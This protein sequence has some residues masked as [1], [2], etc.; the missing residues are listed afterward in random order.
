MICS[1][2]EISTGHLRKEDAELLEIKAVKDK[3][4]VMYSNIYGWQFYSPVEISGMEEFKK[5]CKTLG[6]SKSFYSL[7]DRAFVQ[8]GV[9]RL[10]IDR[11]GDVVPFLK[12]WEW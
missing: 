6:F 4:P 1:V 3:L 12:S 10:R 5:L 8:L 9:D 2:W 7:F 11:D